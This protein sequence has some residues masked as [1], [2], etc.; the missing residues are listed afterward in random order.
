MIAWRRMEEA[1]F[2]G[3]R[4]P[5]GRETRI[6]RLFADAVERQMVEQRS[7]NRVIEE[8]GER[9]SSLE[10]GLRSLS[11][12]TSSQG[13]VLR[14]ELQEGLASIAADVDTRARVV[15]QE[16]ERLRVSS[17][18][19]AERLGEFARAAEQAIA[20][21]GEGQARLADELVGLERLHRL[22]EI[23]PEVEG[24]VRRVFD[25]GIRRLDERVENLDGGFARQVEHLAGR[26]G[27]R[28][29]AQSE[30]I[31]AIETRL[32]ER[33]SGLGYGIDQR[34]AQL[35][36]VVA[37]RVSQQVES[38]RTAVDESREALAQDIVNLS[39]R[40]REALVALG[41]ASARDAADTRE[42]SAATV[43]YL[44]ELAGRLAR[45]EE[46]V[47]TIME[48]PSRTAAATIDVFRPFLEDFRS[49][50][51]AEQREELAVSLGQV[52][53]V[54]SGVA[55]EIEELQILAAALRQAQTEDEERLAAVR[56][57]L[58]T[59]VE[60]L[61][62]GGLSDIRGSLDAWS[63]ASGEEGRGLRSS[64]EEHLDAALASL[65]ERA[66][67]MRETVDERLPG[68]LRGHREDL[69][70]TLEQF[71]ALVAERL[72]VSE[73]EGRALLQT[74][75]ERLGA[76]EQEGRALRVAIEERV[77]EAVSALRERL[78]QV[79][80]ALDKQL[81]EMLAAHGN[82]VAATLQATRE[83]TSQ[84]L[85]AADDVVRTAVGRLDDI[86]PDL[87]ARV[88]RALDR[89]VQAAQDEA[90]SAVG[91]LHAA[92]TRLAEIQATLTG[93]EGSLFAYLRAFEARLERE[94]AHVLSKLGEELAE[95]L[96]RRERK[97][98]VA[99][100]SGSRDVGLRREASSS[101][102]WSPPLP[103]SPDRVPDTS[104][105]PG[106]LTELLGEGP[107]A[108]PEPVARKMIR[109]GA[110]VHAPEE[111][112]EKTSQGDEPAA[113]VVEGERPSRNDDETKSFDCPTCG[114]V[115]RSAGG[116][117]SHRR[118]HA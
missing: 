79:G 39:S 115:A 53:T 92:L 22:E 18:D 89:A 2:G 83:E 41:E 8:L 20:A 38:T 58:L 75:E 47:A 97:R 30:R 17:S 46:H 15:T 98:L 85:D 56:G 14:A 61:L 118:R 19:Y 16:V 106:L 69:V 90:R 7:F 80:V 40:L 74:L 76:S 94:R 37:E 112:T 109:V 63:A 43:D 10:S 34:L 9:L 117:A 73:E 99:R 45:L 29:S 64:I 42:A 57:D 72:G 107:V 55:E 101:P 31:H 27:E 4:V 35:A 36:N 105:R 84:R 96:S 44:G 32:D 59:R 6:D 25:S 48:T 51:V 114:F 26:L 78:E 102:S 88:A 91:D 71:E 62:L 103:I 60:Q 28:L 50:L 93:V 1:L 68:V 23:V 116:L 52:R 77:D 82:E 13:A 108:R 49:T 11:E 54:T 110:E 21:L 65:A 33:F 3:D 95:G 111:R 86:A 113:D 67:E 70:T 12:T 5:E 87:D 81:P 104:R 66:G 100:L 24:H